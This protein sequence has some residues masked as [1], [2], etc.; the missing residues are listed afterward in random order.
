MSTPSTAREHHT[1]V[2]SKAFIK[3]RH[4]ETRWP[5]LLGTI[6]MLIVLRTDPAASRKDTLDESGIY[7]HVNRCL[8][9]FSMRLYPHRS[10]N[11]AQVWVTV[12]STTERAHAWLHGI[13]VRFALRGRQQIMISVQG[14]GLQ[15]CSSAVL[16]IA[17]GASHALQVS[18]ETRNCMLS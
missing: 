4:P 6:D 18:R 9:T 12:W 14:Q 1:A 11:A 7:T 13:G 16:R 5:T 8:R 17:G 15:N 2:H 3:S 10:I